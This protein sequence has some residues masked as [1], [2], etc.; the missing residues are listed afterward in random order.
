M[1][2]CSSETSLTGRIL[3]YPSTTTL[4]GEIGDSNSTTDNSLH[5]I[6]NVLPVGTAILDGFIITGGC[7]NGNTFN[8]ARGGGLFG[9]MPLIRQCGFLDNYA[10]YGG[11]AIFTYGTGGI[12][13]CPVVIINSLFQNNISNYY[14]G[15]LFIDQ[16]NNNSGPN[17]ELT[18][19][20][21]VSNSA[22]NGG[23]AICN[24][25]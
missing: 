25:A 2:R 16:V 3:T 13:Q 8:D 1:G 21:F 6:Q 14:G 17:P 9:Y 19:C 4:S 11:G 7:A 12:C 20:S 18:N 23:G 22:L 10:G 5:V 15:A 24:D